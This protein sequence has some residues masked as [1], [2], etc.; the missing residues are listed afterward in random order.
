MSISQFGEIDGQRV[1][2]ITIRAPGSGIEAS[3]ITWGAV[4]R[5]LKVLMPDGSY[6]RVVL[7]LN[8]L[9]DYREHSPHMGAIAGRVAN[10]IA[11][12]RFSID[13]NTYE[14][15]RNQADR[16]T[17]HGGNGFGRKLWQ[18]AA[19]DSSSV[20][21]TLTSP[22]GDNGF[23]G[24]VHA[25]CIYRL[26]DPGVLRVEL[27]ANS[28]KPTPINLAH[29]SYFNLDGEATIFSHRLS[30]DADFYT[31]TDSD[32]IPTGEIRSVCGTPNDFRAHR[33]IRFP[34][35]QTGAPVHYDINFVLRRDRLECSGIEDL[36]LAHAASFSSHVNNL[37]LDVWTTENGLQ[38]Y[39]GGKLNVPVP[40]LDGVLYGAGAGLCLE[41]QNF[42]DA[43]NRPHFPN[44]VVRPGDDYEQVTEYRFT[45][46]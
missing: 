20:T 23:P 7:G 29:H 13:K 12:G 15:T 25:T 21:L 30:V 10:R 28:D 42:P 14:L 8:S 22:H 26:L 19:Y 4:I 16:H 3:V 17:L 24:T 9:S 31:P 45:K 43:I 2:E 41:A 46:A 38:V 44:S 5:D 11:N 27:T 39:D 34:D 1:D 40:G 32:L 33:T 37:M 35:A 6:Q 18:L 36:P